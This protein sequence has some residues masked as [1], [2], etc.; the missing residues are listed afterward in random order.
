MHS[1]RI[2]KIIYGVSFSLHSELSTHNFSKPLPSPIIAIAEILCYY[3]FIQKNPLARVFQMLYLQ[4]Y[5]GERGAS[6]KLVFMM[7]ERGRSRR[8]VQ[9]KTSTSSLHPFHLR[10]Y[11]SCSTTCV[12][13][14]GIPL[15]HR[16]AHRPVTQ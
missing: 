16:Q 12:S 9:N 6:R 5:F 7:S 14:Q 2:I 11:S 13:P 4:I 1:T 8:F 3:I 15:Q 10:P